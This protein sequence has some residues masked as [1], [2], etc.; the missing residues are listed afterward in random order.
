MLEAVV[1]IRDAAEALRGLQSDWK[2][3]AVIDAEGRAGNIDAARR[4]LGGV[5]PQRGEAAIAVAKATP[6]YRIDGAFA[7][8]RK[9]ALA[10][11]EGWGRNIDIEEFVRRLSR[12]GGPLY[13]S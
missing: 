13:I 10:A 2:K 1:Q 6:L 11:D 12:V 3:Y 9:A 4:V 8:V 5:A 7:A